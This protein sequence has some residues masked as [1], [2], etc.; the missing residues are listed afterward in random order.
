MEPTPTD[1]KTDPT[2]DLDWRLAQAA[3]R[4]DERARTDF[5]QRYGHPVRLWLWFRWC[6]TSRRNL[7]DDA[8]QEVFLECFRPGGALAH[9]DRARAHHGFEA[10]LRGVVRNVACRIERAQAREFHHRRSLV[11]AAGQAAPEESGSAERID[12]AWAHDQVL[13]ALDLL[14]R[15][16]R[17]AGTSHSLREFLRAH[18]EQGQQVRTIAAAWQEHVDHVHEVRRRACQRFRDCLLRVMHG[19]GGAHRGRHAAA[20]HRPGRART[21]QP[22]RP[23][24]P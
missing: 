1:L 24:S 13:A 20:T 18:F 14:D 17:Q 11:A 10:Y 15:E 7:V 21:R 19:D 8:A 5:W 22:A 6:H 4:G 2:T 9:L 3:A 12:R 23:A 16:D